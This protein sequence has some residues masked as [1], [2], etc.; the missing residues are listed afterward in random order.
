MIIIGPHLEVGGTGSLSPTIFLDKD[1]YKE[2][3]KLL[4]LL[5]NEYLKAANEYFKLEFSKGDVPVIYPTKIW[6]SN[7]GITLHDSNWS[8]FKDAH[9][10]SR[11]STNYI[12]ARLRRELGVMPAQNSQ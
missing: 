10:V 5:N 9:H 11:S 6:S 4:V 7:G 12:T 8:F 1:E 2:S 3:L